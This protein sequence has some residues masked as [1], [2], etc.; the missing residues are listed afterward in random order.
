MFGWGGGGITSY[1]TRATNIWNH[2]GS[3]EEASYFS[4]DDHYVAND[5]DSEDHSQRTEGS[6]DHDNH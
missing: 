6:N 1:H 5:R 3:G 2:Y 4:D